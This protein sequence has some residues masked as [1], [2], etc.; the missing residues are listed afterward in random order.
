MFWSSDGEVGKNRQKFK[1]SLTFTE[2][3]WVLH[4]FSMVLLSL[5]SIQR[6]VFCREK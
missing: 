5:Q 2:P 1:L 3:K 4:T 6:A